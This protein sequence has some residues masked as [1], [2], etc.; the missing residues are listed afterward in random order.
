MHLITKS[1]IMGRSHAIRRRRPITLQ[2][3][4]QS[5]S[6]EIAT[7]ENPNLLGFRCLGELFRPIDDYFIGLWNRASTTCSSM[8]LVELEQNVR[9]GVPVSLNV[10]DTQLANIR[11]SQQWLRTIIWQLCT[12]LG[13]LSSDAVH[14]NLTFRYPLKIAQ[15]LAISTWK[16]PLHSM[17]MHGIGLTEKVFDITCTLIDVI[18]CIPME[19]VKSNSFEIGPEDNLK[20]FFSL[21]AQLPG[22]PDKYLP[23]LVTK[24]DQMLPSMVAPITRHIHLPKSK[25]IV[26][27]DRKGG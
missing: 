15:D 19:D 20:H 22:G 2:I 10:V 26:S 9:T 16:L 21:I 27:L 12:M 18:S 7:R 25:Q 17:Q 1:L 4:P 14:E 3:T 23:L 6:I 5:P 24:V 11:V 8:V 13:Y